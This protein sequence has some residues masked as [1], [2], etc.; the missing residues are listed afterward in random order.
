M[1]SSQDGWQDMERQR[2]EMRALTPQGP[3]KDAEMYPGECRWYLLE[4]EDLWQSECAS[5]WAFSDSVGPMGNLWKWCPFCGGK[6]E[7]QQ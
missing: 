4:D 2:I 1:G 3:I 5:Y 7:V 6:L